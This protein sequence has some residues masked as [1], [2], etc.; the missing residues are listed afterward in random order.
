MKRLISVFAVLAI[1]IS[2]FGNIAY[3]AKAESV[4]R[5]KL[6]VLQGLDIT[7]DTPQKRIS[8]EYFYNSLMN[9]IVDKGTM[10]ISDEEFAKGAGIIAKN[11]V[12]DANAEIT[13][14]EAVRASLIVLGYKSQL[15]EGKS[16][17]SISATKKLLSGI[18]LSYT[19]VL[20]DS[21]FVT[22]L[23]NLIGS[24]PLKVD[25]FFAS[26]TTYEVAEGETPLSMYRG[27]YRFEGILTA[28]EYTSIYS[29]KGVRSG[30]VQIAD[31]NFVKACD[32]DALLLGKYVESYVKEIDNEP[33]VLY[34]GEREGKNNVLVVDAKDIESISSDYS[35][36]E[37]YTDNSRWTEYAD[38]S[39]IPKVIYN[40]V[41]YGDYTINDFT[42]DTGNIT[43]I[44]NDNDDVYDIVCINSFKTMIVDSV[45]ISEKI[46]MN[47]FTFTNA[48][49][50]LELKS[51]TGETIYYTII[52]DGKNIDV[53]DI[54]TGDVLSVAVSKNNKNVYVY[55]SSDYENEEI[56]NIDKTEKE[57]STEDET[58]RISAD[59]DSYMKSLNYEFKI[60]VS[61]YLYL[62][63]F[64]NLAFYKEISDTNYVLL[65][66][67]SSSKK[68]IEGT[69]Y[70]RI[71]TL[72]G[73]WRTLKLRDRLKY[74]D[75]ASVE[76]GVVYNMLKSEKPQV[77]IIKENAKGEIFELNTAKETSQYMEDT[78]TKTP[79]TSYTWRSQSG[80]F[81]NRLYITKETKMFV[82][83]KGNNGDINDYYVTMAL[84]SFSQDTTYNLCAYDIDEFFY[85]PLLLT[86]ERDTS[87]TSVFLVTKKKKVMTSD[88]EECT[89]LVCSGGG[90]KDVT[91]LAD[92]ENVISGINAGDI[93][94]ISLNN[95]GKIN[96]IKKLTSL[97]G[98]FTVQSTSNFHTTA[99]YI[100]ATVSKID[101]SG[102]RIRLNC[103]TDVAFPF[104]SNTKCLSY[105]KN[106]NECELIASNELEKDDKL[107]VRISWSGISEIIRVE[108]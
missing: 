20:T 18:N 89:Q 24:K 6:S 74:N 96:S 101:Y 92:N 78:F 49:T 27:I 28:T 32:F 72:D 81:S 93:V 71:L 30:Y 47:K 48:L 59:L 90:L 9:V 43:L 23:Y 21:A 41:F 77:V 57:V 46:I 104:S 88:G 79:T 12:Y 108:D 70:A 63:Y 73:E 54:F 98:E 82:I 15:D 22:L 33:T 13:L 11:S 55:V 37:Y 99:T 14:D 10:D 1:L 2:C 25:K 97:A 8:N 62:D 87:G 42:P 36:L 16:Y 69:Y 103:G 29:E 76:S 105:D 45:N 65:H 94:S 17:A 60:G 4:N 107:F 86:E 5:A 3:A 56:I 44:D 83:P 67:L 102:W 38:I 61:Y 40:G 68:D 52:K 51:K 19:D 39:S 50:R 106:R 75:T 64:G 80:G 91:F 84:G 31:E 66:K 85:T 35:R 34:I 26:Y 100:K 53:S 95:R 58:Y 7:E